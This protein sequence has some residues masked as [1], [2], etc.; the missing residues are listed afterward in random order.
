MKYNN[1]NELVKARF[2]YFMQFTKNEQVAMKMATDKL[3][4]GKFMWASGVDP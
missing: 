3:P 2:K 1:Y 4:D